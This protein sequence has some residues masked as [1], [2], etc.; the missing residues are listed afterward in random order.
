MLN[1]QHANMP[2]KQRAIATYTCS[3]KM[4]EYFRGFC[5][6]KHLTVLRITK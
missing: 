1:K 6:N 3:L 5:T 4:T 2:N